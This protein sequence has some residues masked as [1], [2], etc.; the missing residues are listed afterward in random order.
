MNIFG[1]VSEYNPMHNGHI[2]QIQKTR[3]MGATHIVAVMSGNYVQRGDIAV[4]DK[5]TRAELAVKCGVDLVIELPLIYSLSTAE[6]F[7]YG[8]VSILDSLGCIDAVSFGSE[9]G[10]VSLI[11]QA[12]DA[13]A[14][15][16][17]SEELRCMLKSGI[18]YPVAMQKICSDNYGE[19][20]AQV[21]SSPNN[22]LGIEYIKAIKSIGSDIVPHTVLRDTAHHDSV[23]TANDF[24][25]ASLIRKSIRNDEDIKSFVPDEVYNKI[26]FLQEN[27]HIH[28][29][30]YI[31]KAMLYKLRM[32]SEE[33]FFALPDVS[34]GLENRLYN[35]IKQADSIDDILF[36]AKTKRYP[37]SKLR[38]I[39]LCAL[40][41]LK[42]KDFHKTCPYARVL[43]FNNKGAEILRKAKNTSEIPISTS[44]A[45][46][47][48]FS[49]NCRDLSLIEAR[50]TD[51]YNLAC[52]SILD[53]GLDYTR[54]ITIL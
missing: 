45:E 24:A 27:G 48:K 18:S 8:A 38:R 30:K 29:L 25:S 54:K 12:A 4:A 35:S 39:L 34:Q 2:Y 22:V 3:Q 32:M 50:G 16:S 17:K 47:S 51:I 23:I 53:C 6:L 14:E 52:S 9:C 20:I 11:S 10:D 42:K 43:A 37:M 7:S 44:L 40:L 41:E 36:T 28:E 26:V 21:L 15:I 46:I 49:A 5:F 31:E 1:I 13:S 33:D 19:D